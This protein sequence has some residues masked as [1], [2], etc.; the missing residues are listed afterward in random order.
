MLHLGVG[1]VLTLPTPAT[2]AVGSGEEMEWGARGVVVR[3]RR[4]TWSRSRRQQPSG[5]LPAQPFVTRSTA[6]AYT[7]LLECSTLMEW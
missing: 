6:W 4:T 3:P 7:A 5:P 2:R 1:P